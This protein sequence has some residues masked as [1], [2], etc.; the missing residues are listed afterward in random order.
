MK[1]YKIL[2]YAWDEITHEDCT[3]SLQQLGCQVDIVT[4]HIQNYDI[5]ESFM[6]KMKSFC[7]A[8]YDC[9]FTFNYFP[10]ISRVASDCQ[11]KYISW[12]FDSP[13]LT[14]DS[15]TLSNSCNAI[16]LFDKDLCQKYRQKGI[17]T[18][19]H[20]PLAYNQPR[21]EHTIKNLTRHY[22]HDV[23]FLGTLYND[24]NDYLS[25]VNYLPQ[26]LKGYIDGL[27]DAQ[28]LI[29]GFDFCNVL[30]DKEKC[31]EMAKYIQVDMGSQFTDYRDDLFRNMIRK[32][33]TV[34]ERRQLLSM[35][36][37]A[38]QVD[39]YS[40][41]EPENLPVTYKGYANYRKQMPEIFYTS[42]INLNISLRS[43][44]SGIPLRVIDILGSH[45]F[46]LTNYQPEL[47]DYFVNGEDLVWYESKEDLMDKIG[48]YLSHDEER[49]RI[50]YNGNLK[51]QAHFSYTELLPKILQ[52]SLETA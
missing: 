40:P 41:K 1:P 11:I 21:I 7:M 4:G 3:E 39:L 13:H 12:V 19:H 22:A 34:I 28:L 20:M 51:A 26:K 25:Q 9:I 29:Y 48:F 43:I 37:Q 33:I 24:E 47:A 32:K 27:I 31:D 5:D 50:A 16:F 8:G 14:L 36:G 10:V 42:R 18:V 52:I 23:T 35:I 15:V 2:Y 17:Q 46:L 30:F 49:E 44:L 45:G 6:E 38:Y